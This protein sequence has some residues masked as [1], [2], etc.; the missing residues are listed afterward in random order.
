M[1]QQRRVGDIKNINPRR[2]A[3]NEVKA[4][5]HFSRDGEGQG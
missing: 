2:A 4:K 3:Q 5:S 1:V